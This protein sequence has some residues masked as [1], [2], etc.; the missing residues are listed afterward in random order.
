M[1]VSR[2]WLAASASGGVC[3]HVGHRHDGGSASGAHDGDF[4]GLDAIRDREIL[5]AVQEIVARRLVDWIE[6]CWRLKNKVETASRKM[7]PSLT[8]VSGPFPRA[9]S[10]YSFTA[11]HV[12]SPYQPRRW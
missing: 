2:V 5:R 12:I 1:V 11:A 3:V 4:C 7:L 9:A 6:A 8:L 10:P